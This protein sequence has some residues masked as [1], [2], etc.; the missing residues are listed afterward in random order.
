G[1]SEGRKSWETNAG[2]SDCG[3]QASA[4]NHHGTVPPI[5]AHRRSRTTCR[6]D[7][8]P[9]RRDR[10]GSYHAASTGIARFVCF[11]NELSTALMWLTV[12]WSVS[13][14]PS[15]FPLIWVTA[16]SINGYSRHN[17]EESVSR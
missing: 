7:A 17:I 8:R 3:V 1:C 5:R 12:G 15:S 13:R 4:E 10:V 11:K 14:A 16:I 9:A 6:T 2:Q